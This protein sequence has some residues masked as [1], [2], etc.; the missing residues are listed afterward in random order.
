MVTMVRALS[1]GLAG[2]FQQLFIASIL[3][4]HGYFHIHK[5]LVALLNF[6]CYFNLVIIFYVGRKLLMLMFRCF[7]FC[8]WS[9]MI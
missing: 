6:I 4:V 8:R 2:R 7:G 1:R 9:F 3:S 5:L